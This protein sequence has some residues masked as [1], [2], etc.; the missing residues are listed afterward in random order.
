MSP[1]SW[2]KT[3]P[4][5]WAS[6]SSDVRSWSRFAYSG[7]RYSALSSMTSFASPAMT[8]ASDHDEGVDLHEF[9]VFLAEDLVGFAS[10]RGDLVC[11]L[12]REA[13]GRSQ[14]AQDIRLDPDHRGDVLHE[15]PIPRDLFD[16]HS[17]HRGGH[18]EGLAGRAI[19]REAEIQLLRDRES[20]LQVHLLHA[21]PAD[22]HSQD[23]AGH[24]AGFLEGL[25]GPNASRLAPAADEDLGLH[26]ARERRIDDVLGPRGE[27]AA[28]NRDSVAGEDLLRLVLEEF[29]RGLLRR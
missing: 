19:D 12:L 16:L 26:H 18:Q 8:L 1:S 25:R 23:L 7:W 14:G 9:R 4:L 21:V 3:M 10:D 6:C 13:E 2:M 28:G 11:G 22:L 27:G 29:H 17:A 15:K 5:S 24:A 20:L